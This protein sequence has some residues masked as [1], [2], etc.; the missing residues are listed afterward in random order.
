MIFGDDF[1]LRRK[2]HKEVLPFIGRTRQRLEIKNWFVDFVSIC[3]VVAQ[4]GFFI[5]FFI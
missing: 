2:V 5:L 3:L 4:V 1:S